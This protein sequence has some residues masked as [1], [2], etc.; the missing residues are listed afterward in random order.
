M[1]GGAVDMAMAESLVDLFNGHF[2]RGVGNL[3]GSWNR[4]RKNE[5]ETRKALKGGK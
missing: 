2:C 5:K 1:M 4:K 3:I